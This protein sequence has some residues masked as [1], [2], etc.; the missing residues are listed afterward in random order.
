MP[1]VYKK[2]FL[3]TQYGMRKDGDTFMIGD[4]PVLVDQDGDITIKDNEFRVSERLRE[5]LTRKYVN[6]EHV[7]S[8]D[9]RKYKKNITAD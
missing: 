4:S 7:A 3:V 1:Y 2:Q 5:L 9:K 6:K 8:E